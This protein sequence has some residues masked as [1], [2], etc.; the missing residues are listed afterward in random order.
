MHL[1]QQPDSSYIWRPS[2]RQ[3]EFLSVPH[4]VFEG[5][6]GGAAGGGKSEILLAI[7]IVSGLSSNSNAPRFY[8]L[9]GFKGIIFRRTF[10]QLEES[11]IPRSLESYPRFGGK[12]NET[13]HIWTFP[14]WEGGKPIPGTTGATIRFSYMDKDNDARDHDT[15]EYNYAAFDELTHFTR[16]MYIYIMSRVRSS[17]NTLPA[18]MRS[19]SNP[20]NIGHSWVKDR[21]IKPAP[22]GYTLLKDK[23][24]STC[25]IFI[26]ARLEDNPFLSESDPN[27]ANRLQNLPET[28]RAAKLEG[29]WD[30]FEG[31][32]F[33]E[34]RGKHLPSEPENACHICKPFDIPTYWPVILS[35]DWGYTANTVA[36]FYAISPDERVFIFR[37]YGCSKTSIA[38]WASTVAHIVSEIPQGIVHCALDQSAWKEEGHPKTIAQQFHEHSGI[39]PH[40]VDNDHLGG[41]QLI[42]EYLRFTPKAKR[43]TPPGGFNQ[44]V[45]DYIL[46]SRGTKA[47]DEYYNLFLPEPDETNLPKLQIFDLPEMQPLVDSILSC[48]YNEESS[49]K[50]KKEDV[51]GFK[52]DDDYDDLR[53]GLKEVHRYFAESRKEFKRVVERSKLIDSVK[54]GTMD[55]TSF[56]IRMGQL[57]SKQKMSPAVQRH[58]PGLGIKQCH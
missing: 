28:E 22:G 5:F 33:T 7:P 25:R 40:K 6:Y 46:R 58:R 18:F 49:N 30:I 27:Y 38:D 34:F 15:A 12:Y 2:P 45:A 1:I 53:Y 24:S 8:Q 44:D 3:E 10:P 54:S 13:K 37:R 47:V 56:Y 11:L 43:Y 41:I 39:I 48:T 21:F 17:S 23:N 32:V 29:N 26:P 57:E 51:K 14:R 42:H 4:T 9:P 35:I 52:G 16:F 19:A 55:P 50:D 31:Q 20:G 36:Q